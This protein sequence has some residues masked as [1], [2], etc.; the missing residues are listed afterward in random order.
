MKHKLTFI[1]EIV[2]MII[3]ISS[4][5]VAIYKTIQTNF[6]DNLILYFIALIAS[7]MFSYRRY[8]RKTEE[9][10]QSKN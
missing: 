1:L 6:T 10:N 3:M 8:L 4:L 7:F 9:K 2:W 5:V